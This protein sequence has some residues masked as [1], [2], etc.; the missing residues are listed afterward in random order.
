MET[1][2]PFRKTEVAKDK[3]SITMYP[4]KEATWAEIDAYLEKLYGDD[5]HMNWR[6]FGEVGEDDFQV[7]IVRR[8]CWKKPLTCAYCE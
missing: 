5:K 1:R 2:N 7:I 3:K 8:P 6:G 4:K